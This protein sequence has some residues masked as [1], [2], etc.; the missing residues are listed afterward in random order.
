MIHKLLATTALITLLSG[1]AISEESTETQPVGTSMSEGF[2]ATN[3]IG[4]TVYNGTGSDAENIG[5][6]NDVVIDSNGQVESVIV[7]VGGFL[8]IGE[9]NVAMKYAGPE[10]G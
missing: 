8:G 7:G 2:L 5:E 9:K 1:A 4:E 6:V 10:M 3:L